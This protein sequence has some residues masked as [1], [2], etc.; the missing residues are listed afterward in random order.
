MGRYIPHRA[1]ATLD[2]AHVSQLRMLR[3]TCGERRLAELIGVGIHSLQNL[4]DNGSV[5]PKT[6][7]RVAARLDELAR[8]RGAA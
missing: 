6:V 8:Q 7:A 1:I 5:L 2:D 4:L 3:R